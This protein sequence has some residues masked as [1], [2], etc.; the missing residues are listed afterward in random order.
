[1]NLKAFSSKTL[2]SLLAAGSLVACSEHRPA[3]VYDLYAKSAQNS[4]SRSIDQSIY[5]VKPGDT[6]FSIAWMH[7]I[8]HQQLAHINQIKNNRIYPGQKLKL[9]KSDEVNVFD[10]ESLVAAVYGE[11]L[12]KPIISSSSAPKRKSVQVARAKTKQ[13]RPSV[14]VAKLDRRT[15][16]RTK[17][18]QTKA[19]HRPAAAKYTKRSRSNLNWIWPT[20]GPVIEKFSANTNA[21][22]GLDIA[23]KRG[24]PVRATAPGKVVYK[25]NGLRGYGN[26]VIIKHNDDYLSAYAHN[27]T[28]HVSENE[29]VKAGQRIADIGSSGAKRDK[30]HFEIRYK[31]KPVDPMN[32]LPKK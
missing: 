16:S 31:G 5:T 17:A 8:D 9:R 29:F 26:L 28:V 1:M 25:G 2:F 18:T 13:N 22:R 7:S 19:Y 12:N 11:V 21:N 4:F 10:Q 3:P 32:Y 6:L 27:Q 14:R 23:G 24:Q 30:L 15:L 20:E